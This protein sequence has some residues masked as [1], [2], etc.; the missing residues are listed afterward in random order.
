MRARATTSDEI[1]T[2][3]R[4]FNAMLDE[5]ERRTGALTESE[6][7]YRTLAADLEGRVRDRT[8][9]LEE[10]NRQLEAFS[11]SV[12]HD[13][14]APLRAIDGFGQ[15]LMDDYGDEA[16]E[17][18]RRYLARIRSATLRMSQLID[19]LLNLAKVSRAEVSWK[20]VDLAAIARQVA[21]DLAQREPERQV[22]VAIWDDVTAR[23]DPRLLRIVLENLLG[24][25]WKFTAKSSPA[26]IEVGV[27]HDAEAATYFVRDNG[28]GFDMAH[29]TQLFNAFQRLHAV[30]EY[31]GTG[32]GLATVHRIVAKHRGRI[33]A[34]AQPG[35]GATFYFTLGVPAAAAPPVEAGRHAA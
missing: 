35:K 8:A 9:E 16:S 11:Y 20:D 23:G 10:T 17:G 15:A 6:S 19:D 18:S 4:A 12:S 5:I 33:W 2:L 24:N 3:V 7:R 25:A 30:T 26:R 14:R 27:L 13:L 32:I 22:E 21:A 1:G 29:A 31:P 28:A 34:H